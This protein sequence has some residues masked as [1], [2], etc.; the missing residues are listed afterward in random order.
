M[1]QSTQ[2]TI[3]AR[4]TMVAKRQQ[5]ACYDPPNRPTAPMYI[6]KAGIGVSLATISM[7]EKQKNSRVFGY[8]IL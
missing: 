2:L 1:H 6:L 4:R 8:R 7:N 3:L 5:L